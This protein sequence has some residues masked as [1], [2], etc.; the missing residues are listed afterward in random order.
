M[1]YCQ[2]DTCAHCRRTHTNELVCGL[3]DGLFVTNG[4]FMH[5][6]RL[7]CV[8]YQQGESR[9]TPELHPGRKPDGLFPGQKTFTPE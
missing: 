9:T 5:G 1:I 6:S 4:K 7:I 8:R 3:D 2:N